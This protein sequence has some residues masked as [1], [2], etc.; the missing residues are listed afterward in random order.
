MFWE[1]HRGLTMRAGAGSLADLTAIAVRTWLRTWERWSGILEHAILYP[2]TLSVGWENWSVKASW[3]LSSVIW[4]EYGFW[5]ENIWVQVL[6]FAGSVPWPCGIPPPY[7]GQVPC[8]FLLTVPTIS[9]I[10][11]FASVVTTFQLSSTVDWALWEWGQCL[12]HLCILDKQHIAW[13]EQ[14]CRKCL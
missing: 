4:R 12:D 1:A 2:C 13:V 6:V 14:M 8:L 5:S 7:L 10:M 3:C 11:V 9:L